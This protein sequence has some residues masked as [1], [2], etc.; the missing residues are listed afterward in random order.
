M[1]T[2][3][4]F[5]RNKVD[6]IDQDDIGEFNLINLQVDNGSFV[7]FTDCTTSKLKIIEALIVPEKVQAS[8]TVTMVSMP[9]ISPSEFPSSSR[10]V[11]VSA[12]G[13]GS[14]TPVDSMMR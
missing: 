11:K 10:K 9:E 7:V 5:G 3:T 1:D 13:M 8:T 6:F 2:T 4:I 14:L 12:T